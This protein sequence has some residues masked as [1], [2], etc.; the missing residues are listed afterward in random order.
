MLVEYVA[1]AAEDTANDVVNASSD[2]VRIASEPLFELTE[3]YVTLPPAEVVAAAVVEAA[4]A[5]DADE[6]TAATLASI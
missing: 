2:V 5:V 1:E 3:V 4:A 6:V